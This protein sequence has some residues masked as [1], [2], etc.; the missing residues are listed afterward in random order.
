MFGNCN[1]MYKNITYYLYSPTVV[2][3]GGNGMN[4]IKHGIG[5][6]CYYFLFLL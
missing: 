6:Y 3:Y 4:S 5:I 2:V 1:L